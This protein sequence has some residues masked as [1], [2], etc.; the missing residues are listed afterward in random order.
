MAG[1]GPGGGG[2]ARLMMGWMCWEADMGVR[3]VRIRES[4][5][6]PDRP[7]PLA[8]FDW[9]RANP[10]SVIGK[11]NKWA[12]NVLDLAPSDLHGP[13]PRA[14]AGG[15]KMTAR[16]IATKGSRTAKAAAEVLAAEAMQTMAGGRAPKKPKIIRGEM[17]LRRE[18]KRVAQ[19][20]VAVAG[21]LED[22]PLGTQSHIIA[23]CQGVG[24]PSGW[25][26]C[27]EAA[28][29]HT[30]ASRLR[31][32]PDGEWYNSRAILELHWLLQQEDETVKEG[33]LCGKKAL[34]NLR[35]GPDPLGGKPWVKT[36]H[37]AEHSWNRR[38][39]FSPHMFR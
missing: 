24:R 13:R 31:H 28:A 38:E 26:Q 36:R 12:D 25:E 18:L 15:W 34:M 37:R 3:A 19:A 22:Q 30:M 10:K 7:S 4:A 21:W 35:T 1:T 11:L 17:M 5:R 27:W 23:E 14:I 8:D 2:V 39:V 32:G 29:T 16:D 6:D 20:L 33:L 9:G